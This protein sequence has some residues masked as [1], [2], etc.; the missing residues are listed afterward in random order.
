MSHK[1]FE[2][3]EVARKRA[4]KALPYAVFGALKGG[5]EAGTTLADN[6]AA[7]KELGFVPFVADKPTERDQSV[8]V[9]GQPISM[10]VMISPTGVQMVHPE[11]EIGIGRASAAR[12]TAMGLS[13]FGAT[14]VEAVVGANPQTF[15]QIYW[16]GTRESMAAR[17]DRAKRA[18]VVGM[19]VTLD[20]SFSHG[21]DWGSPSIPENL[22]LTTKEGL[23]TAL[24]FV[25]DFA[26]HPR[27]SLRFAKEMKIPDLSV[28]NMVLEGEQ[29]PGFFEAYGQWM[30][31]PPPTWDDLKWLREQWDGPFMLKG[32]MAVSDA[33]KA[34]D[35]GFTCISVS[36]HGGNNL[37]TTPAAIR[38]LPVIA[39]AVGDKIEIVMDGGIR[40][41]SDVV[42]AVALGAKA[43]MIGRA[44]LWAL[45]IGGQAGV[46]NVLDVLRGG[47]DSAM[48]GLNKAT[49]AELG[50]DDIVVPDDFSAAFTD[51]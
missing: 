49:L 14:P 48:L 40:R 17:I 50:P 11:A 23:K 26:R 19:I 22:D 4:E 29:A 1:W 15:F 27:Y 10:P 51:G 28:P 9:M 30:G 31:T 25:P 6:T 12:G 5:S 37:D 42:K 43:V 13:S 45:A 39:D 8:E 18:G 38:A 21:R 35:A 44:S 2:T 34:V 36:N 33:E 7:F 24:P 47:I 16:C 20:W 41:G 46:E 32:V 3:V